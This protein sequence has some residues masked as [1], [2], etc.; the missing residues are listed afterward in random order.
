MTVGQLALVLEARTVNERA[1]I[2]TTSDR[3]ERRELVGEP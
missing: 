3:E 1:M 2:L